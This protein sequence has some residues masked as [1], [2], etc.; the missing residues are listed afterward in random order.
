MS[1][2]RRVLI[3]VVAV[4]LALAGLYIWAPSRAPEN[5][6]PLLELSSANFGEFVNSF[7]RATDSPRLLLLFSPT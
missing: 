5:Q 6:A 1:I 3:L 7:D 4:L 2:K